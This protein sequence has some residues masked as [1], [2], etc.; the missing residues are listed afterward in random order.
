[1]TGQ[2]DL[3]VSNG[4]RG[5]YQGGLKSVMKSRYLGMNAKRRIYEGLIVP[6]ALYGTK[7]WN[8]REDEKSNLN[9]TE[10][11]TVSDKPQKT[12]KIFTPEKFPCGFKDICSPEDSET[13][14]DLEKE[15]LEQDLLVRDLR[16]ENNELR[17]QYARNLTT[18]T[19]INDE[20]ETWRHQMNRRHDCF[21]DV[22]IILHELAMLREKL[23][24]REDLIVELKENIRQKD[25][26]LEEKNKE[27]S[28]LQKP[29][30]KESILDTELNNKNK[31]PKY[32]SQL[33]AYV[34]APNRVDYVLPV[35]ISRTAFGGEENLPSIK[36]KSSS[37]PEVSARSRLTLSDMELSTYASSDVLS[38]EYATSSSSS[39]SVRTT[40]SSNYDESATESDVSYDSASDESDLA[41]ESDVAYDTA[42]D[43]SD[44]ELESDVSYDTASD[45]SDLALESDVST[46][47]DSSSRIRSSTYDESVTES[48]D[49]SYE[50]ELSSYDRSPSNPTS[51]SYGSDESIQDESSS[52]SG[53]GISIQDA[54]SSSSASLSSEKK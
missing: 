42:S 51:S 2:V 20:N 31:K 5:K 11:S 13:S 18:G 39:S 21:M 17:S 38:S 34:C 19:A 1:M 37:L 10:M 50:S 27:V 35:D 29:L 24:E 44:L 49:V 7:T 26:I 25:V 14:L 16:M 47:N 52:N 41:L 36:S 46:Q 53:A 4:V 3:E 43:E 22:T 6:T 28:R 33:S 54:L 32:I 30:P 23:K 45:E 9:V 8:A 12:R 40:S 15:F 48:D